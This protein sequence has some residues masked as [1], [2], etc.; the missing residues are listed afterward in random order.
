MGIGGVSRPPSRDASSSNLARIEANRDGN[1]TPASAAASAK[2]RLPK[3][4]NG[5][6]S[7]VVSRRRERES[8]FG[9]NGEENMNPVPPLP[10][11]R[12]ARQRRET[13]GGEMR[14]RR[15][16]SACEE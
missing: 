16:S 3:A 14:I 4:R 7:E 1:A 5:R 13:S 9:V 15:G 6:L 2:S 11:L 12:I 10:R 8:G